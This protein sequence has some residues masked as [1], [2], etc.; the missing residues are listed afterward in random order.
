MLDFRSVTVNFPT[1]SG[2]PQRQN[3]FATFGG[4]VREAD[5]TVKGF[6]IFYGNGDHHVL[7][8]QV[9]IDLLTVNSNVVNFAVDLVLRDN[10]G[11]FDDPFG[12]TVEVLVIADVA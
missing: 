3:A 4:P 11:N 6:N 8:Q 1:L 10:S 5:A 2:G 7:R 9:D 12:G